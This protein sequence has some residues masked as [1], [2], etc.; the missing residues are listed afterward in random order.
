MIHIC[1]TMWLLTND[2]TIIYTL[3]TEQTCPPAIQ[4]FQEAQWLTRLHQGQV[5]PDK[6]GRLL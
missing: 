1:A 5:I 3:T 2:L 4:P 6:L